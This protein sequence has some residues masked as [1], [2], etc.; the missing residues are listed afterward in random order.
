MGICYF[1]K[2]QSGVGRGYFNVKSVELCNQ[3]MINLIGL[4]PNGFDE[5]CITT[6]FLPGLVSFRRPSPSSFLSLIGIYDIELPYLF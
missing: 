3:W 2:N 1:H 6:D 4:G 5:I